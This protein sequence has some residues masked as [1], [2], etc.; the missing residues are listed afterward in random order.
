MD[1]SEV[2][3]EQAAE[4][5]ERV[6][7]IDVAKASGM[8]CVRLPHERIEGRRT[9]RVWNVGATTS[10]ILELGDH[11][12]CQGVTRVVMEATGSYWKPWFY[13]LEARGLEC[14]LVNARNVKNVPGRPK[15][16]KI[17]AVW[18]C[19]LAERGM[20]RPSF[21]PP[22]PI[23]ELRDLTRLR[24]VF[25]GERSRN[26][27]R[28]EKV[29]E[30]AQIKLSS[31]ASDIF[32]LSGRAMLEALIGGERSP[33]ALAALARGRLISK[34]NALVEALTGQF[35]AHHAYM[36]RVL[37]ET[38]DRL[39][40]QVDELS[41]RITAQLACI[42]P[43]RPGGDGSTLPDETDPSGESGLL[44]L[45]ERLDEI[46]GVGRT[47]A[48]VILAELG[49][50]MRIFPTANYLA[51]WA[52]LTPRTIQSGGK[53][54]S[55]PTGHG[56]PWLKGM[57]GEAAMAA[58]RTDTFL[59]ARYRRLVKRRGHKKAIVAVARSMLVIIWHLIDDPTARF[60]DLGPGHHQRSV[61]PV[62]RTRDLVRQLEALG[63]TVT[64]APVE[65]AT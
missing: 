4:L 52:K 51:S 54:T 40:A 62:R 45:V 49:P 61:N 43:P 11:L 50:D 25:I 58:A 37:M 31:V 10:A 29:L 53:N 8:L 12:M 47:A 32:G 13:L 23:R 55:G 20:L 16:D 30:D 22:K 38:I 15:T 14:W 17:D 7:A 5:V 36:C 2:V 59:G 35:D 33:Q 56:N 65:P 26:K 21:V 48:E 57:I 28:V 41:E 24:A 27:Q 34:H 63:H 39:T 18:L 6:A 9:Q 3:A 64:L 42:A 44:P 19:K 46:P 60:E 1:D